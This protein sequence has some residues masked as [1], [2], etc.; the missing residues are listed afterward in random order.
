M[1]GLILKILSLQW[2][3][4]LLQGHVEISINQVVASIIG[5]EAD[6]VITI[7]VEEEAEM[8]VVTHLTIINS[9]PFSHISPIQA[10][11]LQDQT[12]LCVKYATSLVMWL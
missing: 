6:G 10:L 5:G 11:Q 9:I 2:L 12:G 4:L 8:Q 7:E 3:L 1:K